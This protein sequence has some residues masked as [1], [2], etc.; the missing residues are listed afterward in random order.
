LLVHV[1]KCITCLSLSETIVITD[2]VGILVLIVA[3]PPR[4]LFVGSQINVGP[5]CIVAINISPKLS[6][7]QDAGS[8][9]IGVCTEEDCP[10]PTNVAAS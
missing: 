1:P 10:H 3:L 7:D 8:N 4:P 2:L 6:S 5:L 9:L